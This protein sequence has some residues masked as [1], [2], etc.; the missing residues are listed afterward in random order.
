MLGD[1]N[2]EKNYNKSSYEKDSFKNKRIT[3][4]EK[5]PAINCITINDKMPSSEQKRHPLPVNDTKMPDKDQIPA[6]YQKSHPLPIN[7]TIIPASYL[8]PAKDQ[9]KP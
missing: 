4:L 1:D 2:I 9:K 6:D 5:I 3:S 8:M 7:D